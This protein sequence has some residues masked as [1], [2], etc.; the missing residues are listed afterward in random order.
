MNLFVKIAA[1]V[2]GGIAIIASLGGF[3]KNSEE[4]IEKK[5]DEKPREKKKP[6]YDIFDFSD[7]EDAERDANTQKKGEL[8]QRT[9]E[10]NVRGLQDGLSKASNILGQFCN[11]CGCILKMFY[12]DPRLDNTYGY[13]GDQPYKVETDGRNKYV[14]TSENCC[15]VY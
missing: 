2:I 11:I 6:N 15:F 9:T 13:R 5:P 1:G 7:F 4:N 8:I 3:T 12:N 10:R 14:W